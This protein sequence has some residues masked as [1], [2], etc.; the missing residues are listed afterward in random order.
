M[1]L[2]T[3]R[4]CRGGSCRWCC[5]AYV[6]TLL[7]GYLGGWAL[8]RVDKE[9]FLFGALAVVGVGLLVFLISARGRLSRTPAPS[10]S[11]TPATRSRSARASSA[12]R[13]R[14]PP[15]AWPS[16]WCWSDSP[17][18][19]RANVRAPKRSRDSVALMR[20]VGADRAVCSS[21]WAAVQS[22]TSRSVTFDASK[23][24]QEARASRAPELAPYEYTAA[25]EY[26]HKAREVGGY[27]RY[28]EAVEFGKKARDFGHEA[29][30]LARE[31]GTR[32]TARMRR[33][34]GLCA[35]WAAPAPAARATI[36]AGVRAGS[37]DV[38]RQAR[39]NGAY[40][41]APHELAMAESHLEFAVAELDAGKYFPAKHE[42]AVAEE[43]AHRAVEL[44]PR[45]CA[46]TRR[47]CRRKPRDTD[48]DGIPDKLDKCPTEPEDKD[49]FAGRRRLP[50][51]R[52]RRR[53]HPRQ[54][55]QVPERARGQGRLRGRGRLPRSR[56]RQGR[57][58]RQR[59]QVSQ[60]GGTQGKRRLPGQR[61]G[62]RRCR[63]SPRQVP[64]RARAGRQRRLP[65]AQVHR[66]HQ[67]EDRAQAEGPLRD[68]QEHDL[69]RFVPHACGGRRGAKVAPR[70]QGAHRR[71]YRFARQ[72]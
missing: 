30:K 48:G 53:R 1:Y 8:V 49:G 56:Q 71:A 11:T 44:S 51:P 33:A 68:Q 17:C 19:S 63:R 55:R 20:N 15:P 45:R 50:R 42:V 6:A 34:A 67:G 54:A 70:D 29:T 10:T 61:Q 35:P 41:C 7:G 28:H 18:G 47:R 52:Q 25:V 40:R 24:V 69:S 66:R 37:R 58:P 57:H 46:A 36:C 62:W 38:I 59:R 5:L 3:R 43:N 60:R 72:R 31:R 23:A 13:W 27:A 64:R 32:S 14:Q 4:A 26:L 2:S 65:E 39:D 16:P 21:P 22:S 12:G 9:K